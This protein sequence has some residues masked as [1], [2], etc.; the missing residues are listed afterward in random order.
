[1]SMR[2]IQ[3]ARFSTTMVVLLSLSLF[4][5]QYQPAHAADNCMTFNETPKT[6]CGKFLEYW[7]THGGLAINGLPV[8]DPQMEDNGTGTF[9]TQW[10]ERARFELHPENKAP[11]DVLLGLLG[12]TLR[13]EAK[14][15]DPDYQSAPE[16]K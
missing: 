3:L 1:M 8:T 12:N 4:L 10:F 5:G 14:L 11:Y 9:M 6:I 2:R 7:N 13:A 15:A 16:I